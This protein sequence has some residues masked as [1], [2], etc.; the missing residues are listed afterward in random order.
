MKTVL[1]FGIFDE[2]FSRNKVYIRGLRENGIQVIVCT[3]R[4]VGVSKYWNI[5]KKHW[6][7]RNKYDVMIVGYPGYIIV[8]LARILTRKPIMFDAL[9]S[10][11]ETE[12]V[13]QRSAKFASR[14][15]VFTTR[16]KDWLAT[17]LADKVL[18]ESNKQK[19]YFC[20]KM[21]VKSEKLVTVYTGVDDSIFKFDNSVEKFK[22]FT[23]LFRGR[24]TPEAGLPTILKSAKILESED[25]NFLIIGYG[26]G[27]ALED[28]NSTMKEVSPKNVEHIAEHLDMDD[29]LKKMQKCHVSL[30]QFAKHERLERTIPH[31]TYE[32]IAMKLPYITARTKGV[33]E[34][35]KDRKHCL[36]TSPED[37]EDLASKVKELYF[38]SELRKK[39]ANNSHE[40]YSDRLTSKKIVRPILEVLEKIN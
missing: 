40:F 16:A 7:L 31:K 13:S 14:Y 27:K 2:N 35:L 18:V 36:M 23:V 22:K 4:A 21:K 12:I 25:V 10:F 24:I 32:S 20:K 28:F 37:A 26:Y 34:L 3:D 5:I 19:E 39:I 1:Y 29:M 6:K 9:C 8:P 17:R 30:G 11:Y 33:E 15:K 38:N